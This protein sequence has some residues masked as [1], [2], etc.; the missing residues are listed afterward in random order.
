MTLYI[1]IILFFFF[2]FSSFFFFFLGGGDLDSVNRID[3]WDCLS[4]VKHET[5]LYLW[6]HMFLR[7]S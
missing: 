3:F 5:V 6:I 4:N 7:C 1:Y 2:F